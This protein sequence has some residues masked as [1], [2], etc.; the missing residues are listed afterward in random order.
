MSAL[1]PWRI[2][3]P[4]PFLIRQQRILTVHKP[5]NRYKSIHELISPTSL[6]FDQY[7]CEGCY[8]HTL[9]TLALYYLAFKVALN[10]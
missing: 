10:G 5:I 4:Y 6:R 3:I 9:C 7:L 2:K 8:H 1:M